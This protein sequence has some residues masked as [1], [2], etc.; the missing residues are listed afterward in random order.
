[1]FSQ[2]KHAV[3]SM[4][5]GMLALAAVAAG[6]YTIAWYT[7]DGGGG[8][9]ADLSGAFELSGT[10]GQ[11]D[12][13]LV[14]SGGGYELTGGFWAVASSVAPEECPEDLDGSGTIDLADLSE[15]LSSFGLCSGDAGY[16]PGADLDGSGCVE[17]AD[18]SGI[19]TSFGLM[20]P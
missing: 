15:L 4:V 13:G 3:S 18:L 14:L 9:S 6:D 20:C 12:A 19:L 7:V 5:L 11:A 10:I 8:T 1:M 16:V 2:R 17:L